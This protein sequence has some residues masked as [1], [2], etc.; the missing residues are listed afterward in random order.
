MELICCQKKQIEEEDQKQKIIN[1]MVVNAPKKEDLTT[2]DG[3]I[4]FPKD[5]AI[6]DQ[7]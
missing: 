3:V 7:K 6:E 5:L 1:E 2:H 4:F